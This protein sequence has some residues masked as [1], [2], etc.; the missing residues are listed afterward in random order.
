VGDDGAER[1]LGEAAFGLFD[2]AEE[3]AEL[4]QIR[5]LRFCAGQL[6]EDDGGLVEQFVVRLEPLRPL[7]VLASEPGRWR[8]TC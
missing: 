8:S 2:T 7:G 1:E 3:L 6:V 4:D 5:L